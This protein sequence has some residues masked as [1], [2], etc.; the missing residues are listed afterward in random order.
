M[1]A[2]CLDTAVHN[3]RASVCIAHYLVSLSIV[4]A[5]VELFRSDKSNEKLLYCQV[6]RDPCTC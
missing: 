1:H 6:L 3:H 4:A 2:P 5:E